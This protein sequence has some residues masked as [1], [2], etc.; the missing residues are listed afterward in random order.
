LRGASMNRIAVLSLKKEKVLTLVGLIALAVAAPLFIKEQ[1]ITGSIVNATLIY[2]AVAMGESEALLVGLL[3]SAVALG[4]GLLAPVLAPLVPFIVVGNAILV[5]AFSWLRKV[6]FWLGAVVGSALKF[7]FIAITSNI[8]I[9]LLLN[10][11]VAPKVAGMLS[12]TQLITALTGS[13]IAYG[14]LK[15]TRK[16][17]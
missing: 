7:G 12:W 13:V 9:S 4:T 5:V 11:T 16:V 6:N 2:A 10:H 1:L 3:P 8:I 14:V 17:S 15:L